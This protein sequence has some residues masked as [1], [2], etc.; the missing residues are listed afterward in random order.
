MDIGVPKEIKNHE[1]RVGVTP[2]GVHALARS[3]HQVFVQRG[4]GDSVGFTDGQY[5]AAGARV[6]DTPHDIY[7]CELVV[8]VKELQPSELLLTRAGQTLFCYHHL[9]PDP[10]LLQ[11]L[12]DAGVSCI[13]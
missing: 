3:G 5:E 8:K 12:L 1:Y 11:A 6:V 7:A 10:R 9:A 13:A 2:D 4:A